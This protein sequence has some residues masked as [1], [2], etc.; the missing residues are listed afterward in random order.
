[1]FDSTYLREFEPPDAENVDLFLNR[2][3]AFSRNIVWVLGKLCLP[4]KI[5]YDAVLG[6]SDLQTL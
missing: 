6:L 4:N 2:Y 5:H 1:M 3:E